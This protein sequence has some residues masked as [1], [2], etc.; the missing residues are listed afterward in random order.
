MNNFVL[1]SVV[2]AAIIGF[3]FARSVRLTSSEERKNEELSNSGNQNNDSNA[4]D[5]SLSTVYERPM[6]ISPLTAEPL[7]ALI[8]PI[9]EYIKNRSKNPEIIPEDG[10]LATIYKRPINIPF[11]TGEPPVND[12]TTKT[13]FVKPWSKSNPNGALIMP[14]ENSENLEK[15]KANYE[16]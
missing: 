5:P 15:T 14:F 3:T 2:I 11:V 16:K 8:D 10:S 7:Y 9:P 6:N 1:S 12:E 13:D 4:E